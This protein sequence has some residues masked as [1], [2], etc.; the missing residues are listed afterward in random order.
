MTLER[1]GRARWGRWALDGA[2][3]CFMLLVILALV[4]AGL[5]LAGVP[6]LRDPAVFDHD[7]LLGWR[8]RPNSVDV[9]S[10]YKFRAEYRINS[11]GLRDAEHDYP[12]AP[13]TLRVL[14][15]GDSFAE[16]YRVSAEDTFAERLEAALN[17]M[18]RRAEVINAGIRGRST[19]Q[20]YLYLRQEG[21]K[22]APDLVLVAFVAG[23]ENASPLAGR[24]GATRYFKPY[25][26]L[27]G[28]EL[29]LR[30]VP[31]PRSNEDAIRQ[32]RLEPLKARLRPLA[33]YSL[34]HSA[35]ASDSLRKQLNRLGL[36]KV[37]STDSG[38]DAPRPPS[39]ESWAVERRVLA[40]M[41][42]EVRASGGRLAL[43]LAKGDPACRERLD[44]LCRELGIPFLDVANHPE[45][46][47]GYDRGEF[48]SRNDVHW[49]P[50]GHGRAAELLLAFVLEQAGARR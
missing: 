3:L 34:T 2:F 41:D 16:G 39:A 17:G 7:E 38:M 48:H 5:R 32:D 11:K 40:A 10:G 45:F 25:F 31:V 19:D 13:G 18:G 12:K 30:G 42:R 46:A 36:T 49:N 50:A 29:V 44:A 23:D 9:M 14:V 21:L 37:V 43:F 20:E 27:I 33:L 47:A 1:A 35:L 6:G 28:E 26:E 22:Y 8:F 4:E 24:M 15:L